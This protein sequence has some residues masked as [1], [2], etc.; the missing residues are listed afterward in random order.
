M[1]IAFANR[2]VELRKNKGLSQEELASA[3]GVS[4]QAVS[5][6]E[7]AESSPE[8]DNIIL[9]SRI[10]GMTVDELIGELAPQDGMDEP[11]VGRSAPEPAE[12][13][14][15]EAQE[16]QFSPVDELICD[17]R[18]TSNLEL[19]GSE[20]GSFSVEVNGTDEEKERIHVSVEGGAVRIEQE[21]SDRFGFL[22]ITNRKVPEIKVNLPGRITKIETKQ[23]AG[24]LKAF[25]VEAGS[26]ES[27]TGGG[28]IAIENCR[29]D[30][31]QLMTGGGS[32]SMT[33]TK[34]VNVSAK[35]GGGTV[36]A[37]GLDCEE[38]LLVRTDGGRIGVFAR[39]AYTEAASGG[40]GVSLTLI[41]PK[42]VKAMTGGGGVSVILKKVSGVNACLST[43]GGRSQ[44]TWMGETI[45]SGRKVDTTVG[46]GSVLVEAKS[47]GGGVSLEA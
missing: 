17:L 32:V 34:A 41:S 2:L 21:R 25:R 24:K 37:E 23:R 13:V 36:S 11:L 19:V 31:L 26:F 27:K 45:A 16:K 39:A 46:D 12:T 14:S 35:T 30:E 42:E 47:G 8:V 3:L 38:K 22:I 1:N 9:L 4:R 28:S 20:D 7:R 44:L 43:G 6:W 15:E 10:Y 5:K 29:V 40:G 33:R 18:G